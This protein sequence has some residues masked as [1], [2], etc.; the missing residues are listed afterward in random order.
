M[1]KDRIDAYFTP[2]VE[3][4][5][6]RAL[7][8]L[9]AVRSVKE[10]PL[11][12]KPFGAGPAAALAEALQL[13]GEMGFKTRNYENYVGAADL[14]DKPAGLDIL[15][16]L[17]VVGEGTGWETDPYTA[18]L[19]D[20]GMLYGRGTDDDKGPVVAALFAMRAVRDLGIPLRT[21]ARL[22]LGTDEESG[23]ADIT[24]YYSK[25]KY[26][27]MTFS[28]DAGFPVVNIEKGSYKPTF[29][30][31]W[32]ASES[33]PRLRTFRG[34][35]RINVV[36]PD[37]E[38][39][40]EGM[41][42][43]AVRGYC[44]VA[45]A[46][47]GAQFTVTEKNGLVHIA[48]K[49]KAGHAASPEDA[50]NAL[51]AL[52]H[53]VVSLPLADCSQTRAMKA[54]Y[55]LLPHGDSAGRAL[56]I[57]QRDE[58]SGALTLAFSLLTVTESDLTGRFDA[59]VP[60]CATYENCAKVAEK[61]FGKAGFG[62]TGSMAAPHHTP[63]ES[64]FVRTLLQIYEDYTGLKGECLST[65]GGTYVHD[66]PGGVAFGSSMPGF[67][68]NLHSANERLRVKDWVLSAK[69]FA[70]VIARLCG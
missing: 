32:E 59:R 42:A 64:P 11:P 39:T 22:I 69:I 56:G 51:T 34:G 13:C 6:V 60:I 4:E 52:L 62:I 24:Y 47:T 65:G 35:Y 14:S 55:R 41:T 15:G 3:Q 25:E 16:H 40:V 54:L 27:P 28:P 12:G 45:A 57:A 63:A 49:G 31:E 50:C 61:A 66:I 2:E 21:N 68:S 1:Y 9:V 43:A 58:L 10:A 46:Q 37:A 33:L 18:V 48:C 36:P 53:L 23:F 8:R 17:D 26:A 70:E 20:D 7:S 38:A 19:K 5:M 44:G 30:A 67:V 29:T